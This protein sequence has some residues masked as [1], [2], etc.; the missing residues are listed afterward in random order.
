[1]AIIG[2]RI[3]PTNKKEMIEQLKSGSLDMVEDLA[4]QQ[5]AEGADLLDLNLGAAGVDQKAL[6][7]KL[8]AYSLL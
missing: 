1:L 6:M 8:L 3:N 7:Q 4:R 2:E 5:L